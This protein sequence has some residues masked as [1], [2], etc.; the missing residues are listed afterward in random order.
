MS[1]TFGLFN[2][3]F[4]PIMDGVAQGTR[5]IAYWLNKKYGKCYV[6]TP[7]FPKYTDEEEFMVLRYPSVALLGRKPYRVGMPGLS[8][9]MDLDKIPFNLVHA[10]CPFSS[11]RVALRLAR[12]RNIPLVASFHSRFYDDF[13]NAL[14]SDAMA[15]A[16][17][18]V[19]VDFFQSAD[20]VWTVSEGSARTL[21]DYGY[22][23]AISIVE[24]G[25]DFAVEEGQEQDLSDIDWHFGLR[26]DVPLLLYVGQIIKQ[27]NLSFLLN[28]LKIAARHGTPFTML[29]VGE[30]PYEIELKKKAEEYGLADRIRFAGVIQDRD[31][32]KRIYARAGLFLFPSLYDTFAIVVREAA[33]VGCPALLIRDS[34]AGQSIDD[35]V[36]GFLADHQPTAYARRLGEILSDLP[37][38]QAVGLTAQRTLCRSWEQVVDDIYEEY[39]RIISDYKRKHRS[40]SQF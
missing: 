25:I 8:L 4:P 32:L 29:F 18:R 34:D 39:Q 15:R 9:S 26:K 13:K 35:G 1:Q 21:R 38:A 2:D 36:N 22:V 20:A 12:R 24:N 28:A 27:K 7:H 31:M 14:K 16:A 33:S 3:S 10:K 6:V 11:G 5:N 17:V 23:G 40:A 37:A 30:G 19:V